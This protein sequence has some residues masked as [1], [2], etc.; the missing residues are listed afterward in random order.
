MAR[1]LAPRHEQQD[2]RDSASSHWKSSTKI[3]KGLWSGGG[4]KNT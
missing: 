3:T 4:S 1:Q 2:L